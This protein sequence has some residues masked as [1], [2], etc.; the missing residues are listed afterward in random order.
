MDAKRNKQEI[1]FQDTFIVCIGIQCCRYIRSKNNIDTHTLDLN[2]FESKVHYE[3]EILKL[4]KPYSIEL[5]CLAG[6]MKIIP[7][8]WKSFFLLFSMI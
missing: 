5:I 7:F 6:Y 3:E 2:N 1:G 8:F 4:L